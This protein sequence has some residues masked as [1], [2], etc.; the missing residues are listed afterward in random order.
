MF[1]SSPGIPNR[2]NSL[3][4]HSGKHQGLAADQ[5]ISWFCHLCYQLGE[6]NILCCFVKEIFCNLNIEGG[7]SV[8]FT[9]HIQVGRRNQLD[10]YLF[11]IHTLVTTIE[12]QYVL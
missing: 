2:H 1:S 3:V 12:G 10:K 8:Q 5:K 9:E 6:K 11:L 7:E 4:C